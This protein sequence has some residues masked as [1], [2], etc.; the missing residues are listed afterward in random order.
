MSKPFRYSRVGHWWR[1]DHYYK[2]GE[3]AAIILALTLTAM[4]GA[5]IIVAGIYG[6]Y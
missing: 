6:L 1:R 3:Q 2:P 5:I 4:I